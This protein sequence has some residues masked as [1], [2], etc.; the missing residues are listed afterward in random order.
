VYRVVVTARAE[1]GLRSIRR[2]DPAGYRRVVAAIEGLGERPR[3][4][5]AAKLRSVQ[6]P[7]WRIRAGEYRIVYEA[8]DEEV[9]VIA[10]NVAPRAEVYR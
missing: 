3:P 4:V 8:H 9:L 7:A 2:G 6:P 1:R 5:G 10:V